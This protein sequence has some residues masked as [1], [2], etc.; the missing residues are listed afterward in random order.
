MHGRYRELIHSESLS[1]I[2]K[3]F[4]NLCHSSSPTSPPYP[5]YPH[6]SLPGH[7][8]GLDVHDCSTVPATEPLQPG[9]VSGL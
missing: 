7:W 1:V 4:Q 6:P 8:L 3:L 9:V 5:Y 2:L